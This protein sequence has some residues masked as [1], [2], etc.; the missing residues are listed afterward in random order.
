MVNKPGFQAFVRELDS[1]W[2]L[3]YI[4]WFYLYQT[5]SSECYLHGVPQSSGLEP[6]KAKQMTTW[7]PSVV[8][9]VED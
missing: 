7:A 1:K 9:Y 2:E 4:V 8:L 6:N 5:I 3:G